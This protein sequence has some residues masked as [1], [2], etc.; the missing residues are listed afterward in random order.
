MILSAVLLLLLLL[1]PLPKPLLAVRDA[2]YPPTLALIVLSVG[3]PASLRSH[4]SALDALVLEPANG[5]FCLMLTLCMAD[6]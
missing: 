1:P 3:Q 5:W 2:F 4:G 6:R